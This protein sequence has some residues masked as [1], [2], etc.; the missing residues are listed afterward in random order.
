MS[1]VHFESGSA[2]HRWPL[3][4]AL[5]LTTTYLVSEVLAGLATGSLALLADAG[6]MLSDVGGLALTLFAI[7]AGQRPATPDARTATTA[8]KF[9]R[10]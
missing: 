10:P 7:H 9:S 6:H 3:V 5:V 1:Q 8:S 2:R 4:G